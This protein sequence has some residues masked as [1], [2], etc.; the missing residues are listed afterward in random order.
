M[1]S[2]IHEALE[3]LVSLTEVAEK[4][5]MHEEDE[6][7][8]REAE[9]F[10]KKITGISAVFLPLSIVTGIYGMNVAWLNPFKEP[11][12]VSLLALGTYLLTYILFK[13]WFRKE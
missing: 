7:K 13:Y 11:W 12:M 1:F 5:Q 2:E 9:R 6:R 8:R 3:A 10:N 4:K